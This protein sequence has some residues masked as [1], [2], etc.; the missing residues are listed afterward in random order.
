VALSF[1]FPT[2]TLRQTFAL[3]MHLSMAHPG[4]AG[5]P[6]GD[7]IQCR[8]LG[9]PSVLLREPDLPLCGHWVQ[10]QGDIPELP[11]GICVERL[12]AFSEDHNHPRLNLA[13][14]FD[15]VT[16]RAIADGSEFFSFF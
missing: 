13:K 16:S 6:D 2:E 9:K 10:A 7:C 1:G 4:R 5:K 3:L 14:V 15:E 12:W 11:P 8:T